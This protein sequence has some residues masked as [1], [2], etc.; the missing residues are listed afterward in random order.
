MSNKQARAQAEQ[1]SITNII[2]VT[3]D[4]KVIPMDLTKVSLIDVKT[5]KPIFKP[6]K[7]IK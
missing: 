1:I 6:L 2:L 7:E 3:T 4:G 5:G